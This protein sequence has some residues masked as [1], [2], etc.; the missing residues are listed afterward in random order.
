MRCSKGNKGL[1]NNKVITFE[2]LGMFDS[3]KLV[4]NLL[5][6]TFPEVF[7]IMW[8]KNICN[9]KIRKHFDYFLLMFDTTLLC[10][11]ITIF[12]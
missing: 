5:G 1:Q 8:L 7:T 2:P 10:A 4:T 6:Q 11:R 3:Q 9:A 12:F